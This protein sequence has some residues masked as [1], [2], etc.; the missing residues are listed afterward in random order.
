[1][2]APGRESPAGELR[3]DAAAQAAAGDAADA[4]A[5][6]AAAQVEA[7]YARRKKAVRVT[8]V[9]LAHLLLV[10]LVVL[11]LVPGKRTA[12]T[13]VPFL[14]TIGLAEALYIWALARK[15]AN[16]TAASWIAIIV[17][18][19]LFAWELVSTQLAI[20]NP[21]LFPAP[22]AVFNV[23]PTQWPTLLQNIGASLQLLA[24]GALTAIAAGLVLGAI[25][26]WVPA[27]QSV[28]APIAR[29]L[30]PIPSVVFSPYLI[31]LMPTFRMAS[32]TVIF[33]G[34]FWPMFLNTIIRVN[35]MDRRIVESARMLG[36]SSAEMVKDVILP[37]L[38]PGVVNGLNGQLTAAFTM[39]TFA[40][41][42]GAS[43]GVGYYI[44]NYTNF[45]NYVNVIA[46]I[47]TVALLVTVLNWLINLARRHLVKWR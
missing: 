3:R 22:E 33:L 19:V 23:F 34:I 35:G 16:K 1:M 39:L 36:L 12:P 2:G 43:S 11:V 17:W 20:A 32:A 7:S 47:M 9:V 4:R 24:M 15:G 28:F 45:A 38:L 30:A 26:G 31:L 13:T 18:S 40:E 21:V 10:A 5:L 29:V 46:G 25:C 27:L 37:Y 42:L 8:M 44:I 6:T 41:M 14:V